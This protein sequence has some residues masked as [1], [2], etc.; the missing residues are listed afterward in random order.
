M[1]RFV[2]ALSVWRV[3]LSM[4]ER[5]AHKSRGAEEAK[6]WEIAQYRK[7]TLAERLRTARVLKERAYPRPRPDVRECHRRK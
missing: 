2:L 6:A 4:M 1:P 5:I 7:M 3:K